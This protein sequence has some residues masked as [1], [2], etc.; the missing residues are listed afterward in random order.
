MRMD[1]RKR[2]TKN[3]GAYNREVINKQ[4]GNVFQL[5]T[6]TIHTTLITN[7]ANATLKCV[8]NEQKGARCGGLCLYKRERHEQTQSNPFIM[9]LWLGAQEFKQYFALAVDSFNAF[10]YLIFFSLLRMRH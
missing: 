3:V 8:Y 9:I 1:L 10:L 4:D 5:F 6:S 2:E 7:F